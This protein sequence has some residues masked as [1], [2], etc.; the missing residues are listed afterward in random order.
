MFEFWFCLLSKSFNLRSPASSF[1]NN[2]SSMTPLEFW[3]NPPMLAHALG[4]PV[5]LASPCAH[6]YPP[7]L[8]SQV[9]RFYLTQVYFSHSSS[10]T[11]HCA[12]SLSPGQERGCMRG[13]I[14]ACEI[15][16]TS[17]PWLVLFTAASLVP[18]PV[19]STQELKQLLNEC[20][21]LRLRVCLSSLSAQALHKHKL[22]K[23]SLEI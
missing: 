21:S 11:F 1:V 20:G 3:D 12:L 23:T 8:P 15:W 4:L 13:R 5:P 22:K 16:G 10:L 6:L 7:P 14:L 2:P 19:P 17:S 18:R 9:I